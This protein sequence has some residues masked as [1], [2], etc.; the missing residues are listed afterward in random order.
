MAEPRDPREPRIPKETAPFDADNKW[1]RTW[2]MYFESLFTLSV[3]EAVRQAGT[4]THTTGDLTKDLPVFGNDK[5]DIK[6]GTKSGN[7]NEVATVTGAVVTG[8]T[9]KWDAN[10]NLIDAG[11]AP[12]GGGSGTVTHTG[13]AL[14]A[15]QPV[16]GAGSAD[17]K[18]GTKT[19]NTNKLVTN[20]GTNVTGNTVKWDASGNLIDAGVTPGGGGTG[21]TPAYISSL[22]AGPDT[23][24]TITG[25]THGYATAGLLVQVYDNASPRNAIAAGWTVNSSTFDVIVTFASAQSNYYI[26]ING[27]T[28]PAGPTG[29]PGSGSGTVTSVAL[30][31][32]AEFSVAGS[33]V[34]TSGTLA[35]SKA[36][37]SANT[38]Y[39]GP[40]TGSA[41]APTFR[42]VVPADLPLASSSA[43]GAVKVDGTT[44]TASSGVISAVG[45]SSGALVLLEQHTASNSASLDFTTCITSSYDDYIIE[46]VGLVPATTG[47][48]FLFRYS[49]DGGSTYV[50]G[51]GYFWSSIWVQIAVTTTGAYTQANVDA[52]VLWGNSSR[53]GPANAGVAPFNGRFTLPNPASGLINMYGDGQGQLNATAG[54]YRFSMGAVF[55]PAVAIN[56]FRILAS[57]GNIASGTVRVYGLAK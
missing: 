55:N 43:F 28:G 51:T 9:V 46:V 3:K 2:I 34:T 40:T 11:T 26:V 10:G 37:Q 57:S 15:D 47:S 23:T 49:T 30:T 4:V 19:G 7:T 25:A 22:I 32:P 5:A 12:G 44:I 53:Q 20:T 16:F 21:G 39:A 41:A 8:N 24:K 13:G 45:G 17:I 50:T 54:T 1:T 36:T 38:V 35:V 42:A 31:V 27:A 29:P 33:P 56:A 6:V 48:C 52:A 14:T 18:V